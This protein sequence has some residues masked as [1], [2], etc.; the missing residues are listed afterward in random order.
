MVIIDQLQLLVLFS[1]LGASKTVTLK[2]RVMQTN[3]LV[4]TD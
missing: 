4:L 2:E 1:L 3:K